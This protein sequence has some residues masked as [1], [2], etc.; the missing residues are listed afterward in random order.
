M[1]TTLIAIAGLLT[2]A[3]TSAS[4]HITSTTE[5]MKWQNGMNTLCLDRIS[6]HN[7]EHQV[8]GSLAHQQGQSA[9]PQSAN[10]FNGLGGFS[11]MGE[12]LN[13]L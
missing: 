10:P 2:F 13:G 11:Q 8:T 6:R 9:A 7:L 12:L 3:G 5:C 4:A 1:K